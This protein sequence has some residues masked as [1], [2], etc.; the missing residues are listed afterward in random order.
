MTYLFVHV[1]AGLPRE[2]VWARTPPV[3]QTQ[4]RHDVIWQLFT[5]YSDNE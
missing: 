4:S 5:I 2:H 1:W 3:N